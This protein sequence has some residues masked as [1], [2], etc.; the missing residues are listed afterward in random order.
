V[1]VIERRCKDGARVLAIISSRVL[2]PDYAEVMLW[3]G[4]TPAP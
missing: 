4:L 2:G 3:H 1:Q